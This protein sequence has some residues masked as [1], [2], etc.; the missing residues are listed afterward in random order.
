MCIEIGNDRTLNVFLQDPCKQ[1]SVNSVMVSSGWAQAT[2]V[3]SDTALSVF[4]L[5]FY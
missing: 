5:G 2:G 1:Q 4:D 3:G